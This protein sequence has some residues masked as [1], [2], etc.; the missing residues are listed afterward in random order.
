MR[1]RAPI[2]FAVTVIAVLASGCNSESSNQPSDPVASYTEFLDR[3]FERMKNELPQF[4][5]DSKYKLDVQKT[6]S[7]VSPLVGTCVVDVV[8]PFQSEE[9]DMAVLFIINLDM[10]HGHQDSGWVLTTGRGRITGSK[11]LKDTSEYRV[12]NS[13][14]KQME[15]KYFDFESLDELG[16]IF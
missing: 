3:E 4:A 9:K 11:V 12:A 13:V 2:T 16:K 10:K 8:Y 7:L 5:L 6:D 1:N 15:G 14:A